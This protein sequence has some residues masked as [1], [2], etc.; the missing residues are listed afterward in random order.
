[1]INLPHTVRPQAP[2]SGDC[3]CDYSSGWMI[4][5]AIPAHLAGFTAAVL[6]G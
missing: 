4:V 1:M 5:G 6:E 3:G 2:N